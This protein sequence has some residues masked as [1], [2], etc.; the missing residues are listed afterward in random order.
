MARMLTD[1]GHIAVPADD[2]PAL[3]AALEQL[4]ARWRR[5]ELGDSERDSPYT[6]EAA[7][8]QLVSWARAVARRKA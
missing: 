7:T 8:R 1:L 2:A 5:G 6:V 4:I 3:G